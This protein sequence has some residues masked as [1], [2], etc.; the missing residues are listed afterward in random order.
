MVVHSR[1]VRRTSRTGKSLETTYASIYSTVTQKCLLIQEA[2]TQT[3][4]LDDDRP[5]GVN[6][7]LLYLYTLE[8][9][10]LSNKD[11][12]P[13]E[14]TG[15]EQCFVLGDKYNL[16]I[17]KE[18]GQSQLL[19]NVRDNLALWSTCSDQIKLNW[20]NWL[21]RMWRWEQGG[22][23]K[24]RGGAIEALMKISVSI[25]EHEAFQ[26]LL[27]D[28]EDFNMAFLRALAKKATSK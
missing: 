14:F 28:N 22:S 15:E 20:I 5:D 10:D 7:M 4:K 17:L 8:V 1:Y 2:E 21:S 11:V 27:K 13:H 23:E 12:S 3:I 9:P 26:K 18:H 19:Q 16:P 24:I 6:V 25:I